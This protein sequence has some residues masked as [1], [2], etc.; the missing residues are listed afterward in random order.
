MNRSCSGRGCR[1]NVRRFVFRASAGLY[2][3]MRQGFREGGIG[4]ER[5]IRAAEKR[6]AK[7]LVA[8]KVVKL[9]PSDPVGREPL[10]FLPQVR[11][12]I[13]GHV[14]RSCLGEELQPVAQ[15]SAVDR[16]QGTI[17]A[18]TNRSHRGQ[19]MQAST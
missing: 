12:K 13:D 7:G 18:T 11:R 14:P 5:D 19:K 1:T 3:Q 6:A 17:T 15:N 2:S 9:F 16:E 10:Q 8:E 4:P